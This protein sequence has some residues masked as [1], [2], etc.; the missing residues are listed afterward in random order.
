MAGKS[1]TSATFF[2][3]KKLLGKAHTSNLKT[4]GEELIG[5]NIQAASSQLF[6]QP[7]PQNPSQTLYL[8]QSASNGAPATVEY[9]HFALTAL[10]G[11][12][13][14]ANETNPDG[15]AGSDSGESSQTSGVHTYKFAFRSD[16]TTNSNNPKKGGNH[17][18][19]NKIIHETLGGVQ[20]IPPFF[21]QTAP[22][23]YIVKI[24]KDDGSGGIG[25]EIPLLDNIDWNVDF[26]NG[27]LFLQDFNSSKIPAHAKAFAYVGDFADRGFFENSL[28]GSL[29]K[30]TDGS[31]YLV[32]GNNVTIS[33]SSNGQIT[34]SS[35]GGGGG[36][37]GGSNT[38]IQFNDAGSF[39]GD[40]DL[41]YNKN[42]NTL[43]SAGF[44]T[45]S[46]G[47]S[48]SLTKLSD[49][50]SYI[51]AGSGIKVLSASN[52]Q[53]TLKA[54]KE[55][56]F[57]EK[58]SGN[59]DGDNTHFTLANTPFASSEISIFVN[60]QLQTP[61]DLTTFQDY[62]VTGSNVFFT[63]GSTPEVGSL[64]LAMYNKVVS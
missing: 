4:D 40:S 48:G 47:F 60:G 27:I 53:I 25:D 59:V 51:Q 31:S 15:G 13:Y 22:N 46:L 3:Q 35:T 29:Q 24:Y 14:D 54:S 56:V 26:Y 37:P 57:N 28:S 5:S 7:I 30:L 1:N 45:A 39:A 61:P 17:F 2:A 10:T 36:S 62:S 55:M 34:I 38:Q 16:Y 33:S 20:L 43:K 50:S 19:N 52:G 44:I 12:T 18:R 42:T 49:G 8:L 58:L 11:T 32:A 21:S 6:G 23:P 63:T 9:I 64:V 41:S